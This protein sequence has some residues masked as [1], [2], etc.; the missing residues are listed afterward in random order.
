[1]DA[2]NSEELIH[3][4]ES[5]TITTGTEQICTGEN[6]NS[7]TILDS[8]EESHNLSYL[9]ETTGTRLASEEQKTPRQKVQFKSKESFK[10][11]DSVNN[12]K[13]K[14]SP[15]KSK[16]NTQDNVLK[17]VKKVK[18]VLPRR[19][20]FYLDSLSDKEQQKPLK[21]RVDSVR[22]ATTHQHHECQYYGW[23]TTSKVRYLTDSLYLML[24][25]MECSPKHVCFFNEKTNK[26]NIQILELSLF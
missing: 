1:M 13:G 2:S 8:H 24:T 18:G 12:V 6:I 7:E 10:L 14:F 19:F 20:R 3:L 16:I 25:R 15:S 9:N 5:L 11:S 17:A 4:S 22:T 23:N 26:F 21:R